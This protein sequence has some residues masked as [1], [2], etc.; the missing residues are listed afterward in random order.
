MTKVRGPN[1]RPPLAIIVMG[2]SG[3]G[4]STFGEALAVAFGGPFIEGDTLHPVANIE[5]MSKGMPLVDADRLP[6]LD[7][8]AS[9]IVGQQTDD[10]VV[11]ASCSALKR[12]Y[13]D[14]LR[15]G[16]GTNLVFVF[17]D[18][19]EDVIQARLAKREDHFMPAGLLESQ[20]AT[21]ERPANEERDVVQTNGAAPVFELKSI[22]ETA[23]DATRE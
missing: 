6:W 3:C 21:L 4:K 14:R 7:D 23:V 2:V 8:L 12:S 10:K 13:R 20:F 15:F 17:L 16:I 11:V 18:V 19:A 9:A 1:D 22:I 5:K